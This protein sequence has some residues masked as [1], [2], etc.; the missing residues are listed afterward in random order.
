MILARRASTTS[1]SP[2]RGRVEKMWDM[3]KAEVLDAFFALVSTR[4]ICLEESQASATSLE[5]WRFSLGRVRLGKGA[6]KFCKS[7]GPGIMRDLAG[8]VIAEPFSTVFDRLWQ[9]GKITV[10]WEKANVSIPIK[11]HMRIWGFT[12]WS[13]SITWAGEV[14]PDDLQRFSPNINQ[15]VIHGKVM[16]QV[17]LEAVFKHIRV[18]VIKSSQHG[19]MKGKSCLTN[20]VAF[21][22]AK[23]VIHGGEQLMFSWHWFLTPSPILLTKWWT[24][25]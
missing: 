8:G 14:G 9:L 1:I 6:F 5:Q 25:G 3:E 20:L 12:D 23:T 24:T 19:L 10:V 7:V 11:K 2:A 18:K 15:S 4:R 17:L 13:A 22:D 16:E 21:C